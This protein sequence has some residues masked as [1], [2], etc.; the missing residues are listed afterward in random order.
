ML[1]SLAG[2]P[3]GADAEAEEV[4]TAE[5]EEV[6]TPEA[7]EVPTA[8]P[9][10]SSSG[11]D[12]GGGGGG[13]GGSAIELHAIHLRITPA[14]ET[15]NDDVQ[16]AIDSQMDAW[17]GLHV[18]ITGFG[19][20]PGRAHLKQTNAA[21][22]DCEVH[23]SGLAYF[24]VEG[25]GILRHN[26]KPWRPSD[27]S[28]DGHKIRIKSHSLGLLEQAARNANLARVKKARK[29]HVSIGDGRYANAVLA[30]LKHKDTRWDLGIAVIQVPECSD[31]K[32][33]QFMRVTSP[34]AQLW[35]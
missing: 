15:L 21:A 28:I 34:S 16:A 30:A 33:A 11:S 3:I 35:P 32:I 6:P 7:E 19:L 12:S 5:A 31:G 17:G 1:P 10:A 23:G 29:A 25:A 22:R 9:S 2:L 24:V 14:P 4:P 26:G 20:R 8:E 18:T 13:G 27:L